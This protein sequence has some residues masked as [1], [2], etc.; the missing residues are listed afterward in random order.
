MSG[1]RGSVL[2]SYAI[3][4][5]V[6][7]TGGVSGVLLPAQIADYGVDMA[8][9]GVIFF[10]FSAGYLLAGSGSGA[11]VRRWG[12]RSA[13]L[14]GG[15][16]YVLSA[17]I[18]GLRPSF[19]GFVAVQVLAGYGMG[20][21]EAVL[22]TY[23]AGLPS[24]TALLNRLHAFFGVGALLGPLLAT[25]MLTFAPWNGVWL[26]LAAAFVPLAV[27]TRFAYPREVS[28]HA[29]GPASGGLLGTALRSLSVVLACVFLVVYVGLETAVGNWGF[30]FLVDEHAQAA[31]AAGAMMSGYWLG[32]TAGRFLISPVAARLGW[33]TTAMAYACLAGVVASVALIWT[34]PGGAVA[35]AGLALLGFFLGPVFP[36]AMA[37]VPHLTEA[38]LVPTAIGVMNGMSVFGGGLL[39]WLAGAVAESAGVWTL[40]PFSMTLALLQLAIWRLLA[41]RMR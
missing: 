20:L 41:V 24:A 31:T 34:A 3:F 17:L 26:V 2:L 10:T 15:G 23:L 36:T 30:T 8:A 1:Q 9:I 11:M 18:M 35:G 37:V 14:A 13:L 39:P 38:R 5:L 4:I 29:D 32:L 33:S 22:N 25:W 27:G 7:V 6:G 28:A 21:L 19:A 12:T 40:V 16:A